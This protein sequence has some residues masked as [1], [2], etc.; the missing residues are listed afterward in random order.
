MTNDEEGDEYDDD[1]RYPNAEGIGVNKTSL[2]ATRSF[3]NALTFRPTNG[4]AVPRNQNSNPSSGAGSSE[5]TQLLTIIAELEEIVAENE[6][7]SAPSGSTDS[8]L[9]SKISR[10]LSA[11]SMLTNGTNA[12]SGTNGSSDTNGTD[13]TRAPDVAVHIVRAG[14]PEKS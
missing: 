10:L 2:S 6:M 5:Q 7:Q 14:K 12:S 4:A 11:T 1:G 13:D 9:A 8:E 3:G